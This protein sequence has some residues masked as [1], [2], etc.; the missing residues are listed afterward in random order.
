MKGG[1]A[2]HVMTLSAMG[3]AETPAGGSVC[4]RFLPTLAFDYS[5]DVIEKLE[6]DAS[7]I[8][9]RGRRDPYLEVSHQPTASCCRHVEVV[10]VGLKA[11]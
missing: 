9:D 8:R 1:R 7:T 3:E 4:I 10:L 5:H 6:Q 2:N 11:A